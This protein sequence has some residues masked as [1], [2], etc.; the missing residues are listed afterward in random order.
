MDFFCSY[1]NWTMLVGKDKFINKIKYNSKYMPKLRPHSLLQAL[2]T[3]IK[4][5]TVER[6]P[7]SC[8][9][10]GE[11]SGSCVESYHYVAQIFQCRRQWG[12]LCWGRE[13]RIS[14]ADLE[15]LLLQRIPWLYKLLR[16]SPI[17]PQ[18]QH[19]AAL[20]CPNLGTE[21]CSTESTHNS[22][23]LPLYLHLNWWKKAH[24]FHS[25]HCSP[26]LFL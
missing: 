20:P 1:E 17:Q 26:H 4:L 11:W 7:K 3:Q 5:R 16:P 15:E 10:S 2:M 24:P 25:I 21:K 12:R 9:F 18:I 14:W 8:R 23:Q 6:E 13:F 19:H 22:F